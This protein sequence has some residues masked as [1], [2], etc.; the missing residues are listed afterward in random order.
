PLATEV[1]AAD[2]EQGERPGQ[3]EQA[4]RFRDRRCGGEQPVRLT[5]DSIVEIEGVGITVAA[6]DPEVER[7][8][9][10][11]AVAAVVD[12]DRTD[13]RAGRRVKGVDLTVR[14]AEIANQQTV[15]EHA[16]AGGRQSEAAR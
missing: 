8:K 16:E 1:G 11:R 4:G 10:S 15:G 6:T 13:E 9:A 14:K 5:T 7:P 3:Q 2:A 12:R